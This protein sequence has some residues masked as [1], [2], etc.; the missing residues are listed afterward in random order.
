ML[1]SSFSRTVLVL[2][3]LFVGTTNSFAGT[4][5]DRIKQ[6]G[7]V[8]LGFREDSLPFS[9][10]NAE[11]G[12]PLGYSI[13]VCNALVNS[14]ELRPPKAPL[15]ILQH[16]SNRFCKVWTLL[17]ILRLLQLVVLLLPVVVAVLEA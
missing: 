16:C 11:Q 8:N 13:D 1:S 12:D 4:T 9:Y 14:K 3:F 7:V 2:G 5:L 10:K 17:R 6:T 15:P